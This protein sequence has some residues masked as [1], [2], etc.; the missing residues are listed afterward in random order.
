MVTPSPVQ[1]GGEDEGERHQ[2]EPS[3][4]KRRARTSNTTTALATR[5][6]SI[7]AEPAPPVVVNGGRKRKPTP[8]CT[9]TV[10][11]V[12]VDVDG[13]DD[14]D[15]VAAKR[16]REPPPP[17]PPSVPDTDKTETEKS[18]PIKLFAEQCFV[19]SSPDKRS[20][21]LS[22]TPAEPSDQVVHMK[23]A[24]A[25][26]RPSTNGARKTKPLTIRMNFAK[27]S[28]AKTN[29]V[30]DE[31]AK[32][33]TDNEAV[34][35]SP[36]VVEPP[37][38][39]PAESPMD[40]T[41]ESTPPR[42]P[43]E[44]TASPKSSESLKRCSLLLK[45]LD[46]SL[47]EKLSPLAPPRSSITV[48]PSRS[49]LK[50]GDLVFARDRHAAHLHPARVK[51]CEQ[52]AQSRTELYSVAYL[53]ARRVHE[54]VEADAFADGLADLF[55]AADLV[56]W[57]Q[58]TTGSRLLFRPTVDSARQS[59]DVDEDELIPGM[60]VGYDHSRLLD[61][62]VVDAVDPAD[63]AKVKDRYRCVL[64][65]FLSQFS[66]LKPF[67]SR[68]HFQSIVIPRDAH[69][70]PTKPHVKPKRDDATD[71]KA[72]DVV[73]ASDERQ[74]S[75]SETSIS[76]DTNQAPTCTSVS[77]EDVR[78]LLELADGDKE[79][80][81]TEAPT[82]TTQTGAKDD[83]IDQAEYEVPSQRD[84][85][86]TSTQQPESQP[87]VRPVPE[88]ETQPEPETR[89]E[90][91][92][93]HEPDTRP[94]PETPHEPDTR[95]E[96][97]AQPEPQPAEPE[98]LNSSAKES[99]TECIDLCDSVNND[100]DDADSLVEQTVD[101]NLISSRKFIGNKGTIKRFYCVVWVYNQHAL[102]TDICLCH[103]CQSMQFIQ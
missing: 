7:R 18:K 41:I 84:S 97:D 16:S 45:R 49:L 64:T 67:R 31:E 51:K 40:T 61:C 44:P 100:D 92:T 73:T 99:S 48:T 54:L 1:N 14:D 6:S 65:R 72:S 43:A 58:V 86:T 27:P 83:E 32:A 56:K 11:D 90:P 85:L 28:A 95:P 5:R 93:P 96:P 20:R 12:V 62:F 35:V 79:V 9:P 21:K 38:P 53:D 102:F 10:D 74:V 71:E 89:L 98:S 69:P 52:T 37:P 75:T 33:M 34:A 42:P 77:V 3:R 88:P 68:V 39:L 2:P 26:R 94:E 24:T 47:V 50:E 55:T 46:A 103:I 17:P 59:S 87:E 78:N 57:D 80:A 29:G 15:D 36:K 70:S 4:P 30:E 101:P 23:P 63:P 25:P 13:T 66:L 76:A 8:T 91:E 19:L 22:E 82:T 81:A 60:L